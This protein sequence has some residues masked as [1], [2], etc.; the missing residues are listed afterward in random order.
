MTALQIVQ[1]VL[2]ILIALVFIG[3]GIN[4]FR[5]KAARG[6]AAMIPPWMKRGRVLTGRNLVRFTGVCEIV[7]GIG[8]LVPWTALV[9]GILLMIFLVAV[10]P[11]NAYAAEHPDKFG[12]AA[13]PFWPRFVAQVVFIAIIL[14]AVAPFN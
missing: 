3:M 14:V 12:R 6:M 1:I 7:G 13:I 11:A 2:R 8:I 10:F 5:P 4:H 9:A